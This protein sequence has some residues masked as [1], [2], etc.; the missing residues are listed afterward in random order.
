MKTS[1]TSDLQA[2]KVALIT[3]ANSGIGRVTAVDLARRG[4]HVV[5]ACRSFDKTKPVLDQIA[6]LG[7]GSGS[8]E[9]IPLELGDLSSVR[10]C[11]E[12]FLKKGLP[13]QLLVLNAGLAGQKGMTKS[14]FEITFG[15]C[16]L[17]HFLLT[18]LLLDRL[19]SSKPSRIVV[20]SSKLHRRVRGI[21]FDALQQPTSSVGGLREYAVAKLANLLFA[22][23]LARRL[24]GSGVTSYAI[25]PGIVATNVWRS[26]PR[27]LASILK[28]WMTSEEDGARTSLYCATDPVLIK[29]SGLY[30]ENATRVAPSKTAADAALARRLW[31]ESEK[32]TQSA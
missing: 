20:V 17:G 3:G 8:A 29:E 5:L 30:Y 7:A 12:T 24:Q 15:V 26:M 27:P 1:T 21:D 22:R 14:G 10:A 32:W 4:Y 25:H 23:E 2:R 16:H 13:L 18:R 28:R 9:F 11:A 19:K 6:Q 31:D